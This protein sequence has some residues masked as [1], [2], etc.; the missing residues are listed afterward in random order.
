MTARWM[1]DEAAPGV[2][3]YSRTHPSPEAPVDRVEPI[4][5]RSPEVR[6]AERVASRLRF[7]AYCIA[8]G[9]STE[10]ATAPPRPGRCP[11]CGGSML[12]EPTAS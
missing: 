4:D 3:R 9:R 8:C 5:E 2:P 11:H 12:V 7:R 6:A 1:P 10:S